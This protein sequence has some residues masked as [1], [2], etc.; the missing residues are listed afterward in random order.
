MP[1][2]PG[3][4]FFDFNDGAEVGFLEEGVVNLATVSIQEGRTL[5]EGGGDWPL[6]P[7][8]RPEGLS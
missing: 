6:V 2:G 4:V 7:D 8:L 1:S 3:A 5:T